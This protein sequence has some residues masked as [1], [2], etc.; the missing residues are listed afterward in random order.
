MRSPTWKGNYAERLEAIQIARRIGPAAASLEPEVKR[1]I[2][3]QGGSYY[4][5]YLP[6]AAEFALEA[7]HPTTS[8]D[9]P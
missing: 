3:M 4:D 2:G 1:L 9:D 5:R 7:I 6:S 8:E